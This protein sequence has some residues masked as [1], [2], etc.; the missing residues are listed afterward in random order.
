MM[1]VDRR[2]PE[3]GHWHR[4]GIGAD[5]RRQHTCDYREG[6]CRQA[7]NAELSANLGWA[8]PGTGSA[9]AMRRGQVLVHEASGFVCTSRRAQGIKAARE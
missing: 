2:L 3:Q 8:I 5:G 1:L 4:A 6:G 9:M 7:R